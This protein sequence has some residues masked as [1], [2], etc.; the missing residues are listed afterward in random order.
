MNEMFGCSPL[1]L[2]DQIRRIDPSELDDDEVRRQLEAL[3]GFPD[4]T[5]SGG[6]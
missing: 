4:D 3:Q 5:L 2:L 1:E 6:V